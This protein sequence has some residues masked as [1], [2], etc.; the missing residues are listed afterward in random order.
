MN[1]F[2]RKKRTLVVSA[3]LMTLAA[4]CAQV[5]PQSRDTRLG[6]RRRAVASPTPLGIYYQGMNGTVG[7]HMIS[8][9]RANCQPSWNADNPRIV[10]GY[11][12]PGLKVDGFKI[13]G[14]PQLP[15]RWFVKMR[16][17]G[18]SCQGTSYSDQDVDVNLNIQGDA[19]R[20]VQ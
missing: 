8:E 12:P 15:G 7:Y 13:V 17:T 4:G 9:P 14:T 18:V 11:L 10:E 5:T 2:I 3:L 6:T 20:Q 16:F 19:P 1:M